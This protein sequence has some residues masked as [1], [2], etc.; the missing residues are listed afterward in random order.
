VKRLLALLCASLVLAGCVT[1]PEAAKQSA[2]EDI[3]NIPG[4]EKN[5]IYT[6]SKI[7]IAETFNSAKAVIEIDDKEMGLI[8][9]N[10]TIKF[11]CDS[12]QTCLMRSSYNLR[13]TMRVDI[14]NQKIKTTFSNLRMVSTYYAWEGPLYEIDFVATKSALIDLNRKMSQSLLKVDNSTW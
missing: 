11:P 10:G 3:V 5:E 12:E 1:M 9:G 6:A 14:K 8:I 13:F 7:W 2:I 4:K